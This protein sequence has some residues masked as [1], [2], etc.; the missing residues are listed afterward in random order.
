MNV[1][2]SYRLHKVPAVEKDVQHQIEKLQ[3]RLQ[4]F[5]PE[6][7]HLKGVVE[8]I[9]AREGINVSLNLRLPSGQMAA[10]TSASTAAAAVKSAFEDLLQQVSKHKDL[11]RSSHKWQR[12]KRGNS[13]RPGAQVREVP[14]EQ[15]LAAV[16]PATVSA[17]DVRSYVNVNLARLERFVEREIYFREAQEDVAPGTLTKEEV[18]D[19][20]IAAALGNGQEKPERLALEPWLYRLALRALDELS[21]TD[22][23]NGRAIHLEDSARRPNVKASD[24]PELQFHQPDESMT[25]ETVIPDARV[26]TPEQIMASDEMLRLIASALRDLGSG[27]REAF[28]LYAIEGFGISEIMAITGLPSDRVLAFISAAREHLRKAPILARQFERR[29]APTGAA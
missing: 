17:D 8:E 24:E 1:H 14:F 11:L 23:S 9:S 5:R 18:I 22:E 26:S 6:L 16:F 15:T 12:G 2:V 28:I 3:K 13:S 29:L 7:I 10:Q 25:G 27:P 4:I 19:E 20:T 21:R